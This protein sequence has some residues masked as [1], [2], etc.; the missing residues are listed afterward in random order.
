[1]RLT[2]WRPAL[3][4]CANCSQA[5]IEGAAKSVRGGARDVGTVCAQW[6][7]VGENP[8]QRPDFRIPRD[9][10][11]KTT[12]FPRVSIVREQEPG[13]SSNARFLI[14]GAVLAVLVGG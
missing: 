3:R 2:A 12:P 9:P 7:G 4:I 13:L 14:G 1:M 6:T 10:R 5:G 11:D 8:M